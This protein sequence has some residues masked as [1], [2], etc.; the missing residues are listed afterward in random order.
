M[1]KIVVADD[2]PLF[3]TA[4]SK[5][6]RQIIKPSHIAEAGTFYEMEELIQN[7]YIPDILILDLK[8]PGLSSLDAIQ[9][10]RHKLEFTTIIVVSMNTDSNII[11]AVMSKGINGYIS[12]NMP[13]KEFCENIKKIIQGQMV[14]SF[15]PDEIPEFTT[16]LLSVPL[17]TDR[18]KE[19]LSLLVQG[20]SNKQIASKLDISPST[21]KIHVSSILQIINLPSR[22]KIIAQYGSFRY[23]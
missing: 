3:R 11:Q 5:L 14:V 8:F 15:I 13:S 2:H 6:L 18:Q 19:V 17:L 12:K 1:Q 20:Y 23:P 4:L 21:V 7:N 16:S 9:R 10:I 22:A